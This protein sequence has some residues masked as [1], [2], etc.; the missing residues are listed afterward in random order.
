MKGLRGLPSIKTDNKDTAVEIPVYF[1]E[2]VG[3]LGENKSVN[4][5]AH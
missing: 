2:S 3:I 5:E 1:P 4:D